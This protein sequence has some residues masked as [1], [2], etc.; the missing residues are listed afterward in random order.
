MPGL[1]DDLLAQPTP[2][3]ARVGLFDDLIGAPVSPPVGA[4][5]DSA[6]A[7]AAGVLRG[8]AMIPGIPGDVQS[9][10]GGALGWIAEK[11]GLDQSSIVDAVKRSLPDVTI[12]Q[13]P[14][15]QDMANLARENIP[16]ANYDPTTTAGAYARTVGE[17]LPLALAPV[18]AGGTVARALKYG[19]APGIA[20]EAAGQATKGTSYEPLARAAGALAGGVG[21]AGAAALMPG[22]RSAE[23]AISEAARGLTREDIQAGAD[24]IRQARGRGVTLTWPEALAQV[25]GETATGLT[26]LQRLAETD[27]AG[28][29]VLGPIMAERPAQVA[30]AVEGQ[31]DQIAPA[32]GNVSMVGPAARDAA[33]DEINRVRITQ[34][35]DP[36]R[37]Y[38]QAAANDRVPASVMYQ[39]IRMPGWR[40]AADRV[41][42]N[43]HLNQ[44]LPRNP[45]TGEIIENNA[46]FIDM[47]KQVLNEQAQ[48]AASPLNPRASQTMAA[49]LGRAADESRNAARAASP[50][51]DNALLEQAARRAQFLAP[52]QEGQMGKLAAAGDTRAAGEALLPG[53]P[54]PGMGAETGRTVAA[55]PAQVT[56][57]LIRSRLEDQFN[58]SGKD[59]QGGA[60][61]YSGANFRRDVYGSQALRENVAAALGALPRGGD[62]ARGF[63]ELMTVFE[64]TGRRER[65]GSLTAMNTDA[66]RN[67]ERGSMLGEM[68]AGVTR[69]AEALSFIRERYRAWT[70]G[71][72]T[73]SLARFLADPANQDRLVALAQVRGDGTGAR[74]LLQAELAR[75]LLEG[76]NSDMVD[77]MINGGGRP[78]D[79]NR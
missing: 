28:K 30:Q 17:F 57:P 6:R 42:R 11:T 79:G 47:V 43:P 23:Q 22:P 68:L 25:R 59:I 78:D 31:L 2:G 71:R 35:N 49:S 39:L 4:L 8:V 37:A 16:G 29:R 5:E 33:T 62:I 48:S 53:Q 3:Q 74:I 46:L 64:A 55:L 54:L 67:M 76:R 10:A 19:A 65:A 44:N 73:E 15:S 61:Q 51:L 26:S 72:N 41:A 75:Q 50:S 36:T 56:A 21:A 32:P 77:A 34:V 18:G 20:S 12:P 13:L 14:T 70:L 63:D 60:N 69:P 40:A 38:Y 7:G 45:N 27:A 1:F 52:L 66:R 9:L 58:R 24:L